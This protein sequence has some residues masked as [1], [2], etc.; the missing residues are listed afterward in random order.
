MRVGLSTNAESNLL[1]F[2][3]I[4]ATA[5]H[6]HAVDL[7]FYTPTGRLR[8]DVAEFR[9]VRPNARS[10]GVVLV[11]PS[12]VTVTCEQHSALGT[13]S[14]I[15][16]YGVPTINRYGIDNKYITY[17]ISYT[18]KTEVDC[19]RKS[20]FRKP[21]RTG[22]YGP[23]LL[24]VS[25]QLDSAVTVPNTTNSHLRKN[26]VVQYECICIIEVAAASVRY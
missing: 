26:T 14:T 1:W 3:T 5:P 15:N 12:H 8:K 24:I 7:A 23:D 22:C 16:I 6:L 25:D 20:S 4:T 9:P 2:S 17:L 13:V 21:G 10:K 18:C 19:W 11:T